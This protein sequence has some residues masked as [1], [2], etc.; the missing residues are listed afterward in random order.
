MVLNV[1]IDVLLIN[2]LNSIRRIPHSPNGFQD[3]FNRW[4]RLQTE[5]LREYL[6]EP[7]PRYPLGDHSPQNP[8]RTGFILHCLI[9]KHELLICVRS[10]AG[11]E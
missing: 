10:V 1:K 2:M 8:F 3:L 6:G 11:S 4:P 9:R 7:K 5:V